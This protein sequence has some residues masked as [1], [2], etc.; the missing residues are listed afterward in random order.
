MSFKIC[1]ALRA[2][3]CTSIFYITG[4][5]FRV[6]GYSIR[7]IICFFFFL[8]SL[9]ARVGSW[10]GN[11]LPWEPILYF[12]RS[13]TEGLHC[14]VGKRGGS[15]WDHQPAWSWR[16]AEGLKRS[17]LLHI[18]VMN[19]VMYSHSLMSQNLM[20]LCEYDKSLCTE[21]SIFNLLKLVKFIALL[22]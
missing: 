9:S 2:T 5:H 22:C 11:L 17:F 18:L 19:M 15:I 7:G 16:L 1:Q 20:L 6:T 10:M 13:Q 21:I 8:G 14:L 12:W 3:T 4:V